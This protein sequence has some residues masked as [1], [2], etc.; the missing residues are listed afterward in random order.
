MGKCEV[1]IVLAEQKLINDV[2]RD[3]G[4]ILLES[5]CS[6]KIIADDINKT[7]QLKQVKV[8]AVKSEFKKKDS[9][10]KENPE[11]PSG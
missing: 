7:I 4:Y 6:S 5:V 2:V 8:E 10:E 3:P 11:G 1:R 9:E